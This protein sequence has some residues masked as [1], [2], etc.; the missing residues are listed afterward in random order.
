[1]FEINNLSFYYIE[2]CIYP[3]SQSMSCGLEAPADPPY[4]ESNPNSM[5]MDVLKTSL[6]EYEKHIE[7]PVTHPVYWKPKLIFQV[8]N[9]SSI[10]SMSVIPLNYTEKTILF[11]QKGIREEGTIG[12][13]APY[14]SEQQQEEWNAKPELPHLRKIQNEETIDQS[15][16]GL[17]EKVFQDIKACLKYFLLD[18]CTH[19]IV[20]TYQNPAGEFCSLGWQKV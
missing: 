17:D 3:R 2:G 20:L 1:M 13:F 11:V 12:F 10:V 16:I 18:R 19:A 8:L 4:L 15:L 5:P 6:D 7:W 9:A 14:L